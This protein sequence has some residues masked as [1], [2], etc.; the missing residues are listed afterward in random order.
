MLPWGL[1][2]MERDVMPKRETKRMMAL[3]YDDAVRDILRSDGVFKLSDERAPDAVWEW[4][5]VSW[6]RV[7]LDELEPHDRS[8]AGG[9]EAEPVATAS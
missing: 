1:A 9:T 7:S 2:D 5:G 6:R 3:A 4:N 8:G